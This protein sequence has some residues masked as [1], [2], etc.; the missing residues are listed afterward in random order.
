MPG[1]ARRAPGWARLGVV[2]KLTSALSVPVSRLCGVPGG[3]LGAKGR[4][5]SSHLV[6]L[7]IVSYLLLAFAKMGCREGN[8]CSPS[9]LS[10][11]LL[12][13]VESVCVRVC[14]RFSLSAAV[15]PGA[16]WDFNWDS[17]ICVVPF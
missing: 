12:V 1:G 3:G 7:V 17:L 9:L 2:V 10:L 6:V 16:T 5:A 11:T 8:S 14:S 15:V 13:R 4:R